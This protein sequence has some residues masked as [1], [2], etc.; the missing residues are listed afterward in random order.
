MKTGEEQG[1]HSRVIIGVIHPLREKAR[2]QLLALRKP[3]RAG[4]ADGV[5]L[6]VP[7]P[8]V[9]LSQLPGP[10]SSKESL[11][12]HTTPCREAGLGCSG[13]SPRCPLCALGSLGTQRSWHRAQP[14][15]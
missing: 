13:C 15:F 3:T 12:W 14:Q 11:G 1:T 10:D 4:G 8:G 6:V 7:A 2:D 9:T 5:N